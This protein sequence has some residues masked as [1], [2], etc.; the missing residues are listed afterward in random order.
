MIPRRRFLQTAATALGLGAGASLYTWRVE[1]HWLEFVQRALPIAGLPPDWNGK[2]LVQLSDLH[3]GPQVDDRYLLRTFQRVREWKPDVVVYTGDFT[4]HE[5]GILDHAREL[6]R[7]LPLGRLGTFG[8][9]G[10]HDYGRQWSQADVADGIAALA[11]EAGVRIL[12]NAWAEVG[13]FH[14]VGLDDLWAERMDLAAAFN[15]LPQRASCI[16][17]SHNP[18]TVDLPGWEGYSGWILSGHTHGGQCKPPFLPPP[19]LPVRNRRYTSGELAL[20]GE[21]R[22]Y[23][24]RGVGHLHRLRFNV[25]PEV[26]VFRMERASNR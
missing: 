4:S 16:V 17:L 3:I 18:D 5:A 21:R 1:P 7:H 2:T 22:L 12:R 15:G 19:I 6:F 26:T 23:I 10:N 13:G 11:L 8:I 9:L 25:R 14:V 20:T 24:S